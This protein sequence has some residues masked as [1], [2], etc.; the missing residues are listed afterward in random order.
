MNKILKV[1]L[2]AFVISGL[3]TGCASTSITTSEQAINALS[4]TGY[5]YNCDSKFEGD[6][7]CWGSE[8]YDSNNI[9]MRI[10]PNQKGLAEYFCEVSSGQ[11]GTDY[12][13]LLG[14]NWW[15][16]AYGPEFGYADSQ[17]FIYEK[18]QEKIGGNLVTNDP[19]SE[20]C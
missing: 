20:L 14:E 1:G 2:V 5:V 18:L 12:Y 13:F 4:S 6:V 19:W 3:F 9:H 16:E 17:K 8:E 11:I 7:E 10:Y 15:L